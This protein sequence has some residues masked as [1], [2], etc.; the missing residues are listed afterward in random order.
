MPHGCR[1]YAKADDT[2]QATMCIYPQSDHALP[3]WKCVF[4]RC[5]KYPCINLLDQETGNQNSN[6]TPSMRFQNFH[7]IGRCTAHGRIT[8]KDKN[9]VTC[10]NKNLHQMNRQTYTTENS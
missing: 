7:I 3:H 10:V 6:T 5:A 9:Y 2:A 1:I 8:Q 4:W